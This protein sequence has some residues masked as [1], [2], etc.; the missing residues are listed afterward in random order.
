MSD[1]LTARRREEKLLLTLEEAGALEA[2]V[3]SRFRR[4][5]FAGS[6]RSR[7][8]TIYLDRPDGSLGR[9]L[10]LGRGA[11]TRIRLRCYEGTPGF[12][13]ELKWRHGEVVR[14]KRVWCGG[15]ADLQSAMQS[16]KLHRF[17]AELVPICV[18]AYSRHV[19]EGDG[20]RITLDR[21]LGFSP[22]PAA[23]LAWLLAGKRVDIEQHPDA[24][25]V[26][27]IKRLGERP[28]WLDLVGQGEGL[29]FSKFGWALGFIGVGEGKEENVYRFRGDRRERQ[30]DPLQQTR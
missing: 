11:R 12:A 21:E 23:C 19:Y 16:L 4:A 6:D 22:E 7:V 15:M 1:R 9:R 24:P 8:T 28:E 18:V 14:K 30:D 3:A 25:A 27:E 13:V 5:R 29:E 10:L 17:G 20:I 2:L 26:L